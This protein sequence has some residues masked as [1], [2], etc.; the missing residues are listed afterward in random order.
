M[1]CGKQRRWG[2]LL[3]LFVL[4][5]LLLL[6]PL[7]GYLRRGLGIK[8]FALTV[9]RGRQRGRPRRLDIYFSIGNFIY[10][11]PAVG[12]DARVEAHVNVSF[13]DVAAE[14]EHGAGLLGDG[15]ATAQCVQQHACK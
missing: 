6:A 7:R 13:A 8:R 4:S 11:A 9:G 12:S 15:V 3:Y 5:G 14:D 10:E 1:S 2:I